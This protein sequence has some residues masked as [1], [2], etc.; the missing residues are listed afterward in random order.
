MRDGKP[1]ATKQE[2]SIISDHDQLSALLEMGAKLHTVLSNPIDG[3]QF[4]LV[5]EVA[6]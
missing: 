4:V 5:R 6:R 2:I 1:A 3:I